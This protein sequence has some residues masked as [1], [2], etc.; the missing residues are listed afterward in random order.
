MPAEILDQLKTLREGIADAL[1]ADPRVLTLNALDRSIVEIGGVLGEAGSHAPVPFHFSPDAV[2]APVSSQPASAP[3]DSQPTDGLGALQHIKSLREGI[4]A[5]MRKDPRYLTLSTLDRSIAEIGGVLGTAGIATEA[6]GKHLGHAATTSAP[7]TKDT[8]ETEPG[9]DPEP[10]ERAPSEPASFPEPDATEAVLE[11]EAAPHPVEGAAHEDNTS[12]DTTHDHAAPGPAVEPEPEI[13]DTAHVGLVE[14]DGAR[15]IEDAESPH[16]ED[17]HEH[18]HEAPSPDAHTE[19]PH[20]AVAHVGIEEQHDVEPEAWQDLEAA[21]LGSGYKPMAPKPD[22][23]IYQPALGVKF[24]RLPHRV[25]LRSLM[26]PV[27]TQGEIKSCVADAVA[28]AL[29]LTMRRMGRPDTAIS[30]L[31][32]Y[33]NARWRDG[34]AAHDGGSTIQFAMDTLAKFGACTEV[35]WPFDAHL[36]L[37]KPGAEAY[38]DAAEHRLPDMGRMDL[39]RVPRKLDAWKQALAEGKPIVFGCLLFA[40]FG[41]CPE[42]GGVVPMPPPT[43]LAEAEHGAH[44][45]CAV[46]YSDSEQVFIVRNCWGADWGDEGHCYMPYAYLMNP[47]FNDGD[48]WV[49]VPKQALQP[50]RDLWSD[51]SAPVTNGG[52]GVDFPIDPFAIADYEAVSVDF[53]APLRKPY[54]ASVPADYIEQVDRVAKGRWSDIES[55]DVTTYLAVAAALS[56]TDEELTGDE[57]HE[58]A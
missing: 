45:M 47:K 30:R 17:H 18:E 5:A 27:E 16:F 10:A 26:A 46:G 58:G 2:A 25:D 15:P 49:L 48:C 52:H 19:Q 37:K 33:Y 40:S 1:R 55:F 28:A 36:A 41:E 56:G 39:A 34:M 8:A 35:A 32:V 50:P 51:A 7:P 53:F 14:D 29:D 21:S 31:F 6:M 57:I 54:N 12:E 13:E 38:K 9:E 20:G 22:G 24:G 3:V 11:S 23:A 4:V 42:R 43:E 44:A